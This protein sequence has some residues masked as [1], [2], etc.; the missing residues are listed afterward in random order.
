MP[1]GISLVI[2]ILSLVLNISVRLIA[3]FSLVDLE[4]LPSYICC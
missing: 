2:D 3:T 4:P 1:L